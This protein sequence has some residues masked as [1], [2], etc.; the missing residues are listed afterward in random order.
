MIVK[1]EKYLEKKF[2]KEYIEYKKKV[3]AVFPKL[4]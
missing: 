2:G 4:F 1:E 3:N